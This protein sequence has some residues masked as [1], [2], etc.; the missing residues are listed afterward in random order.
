MLLKL[1]TKLHLL[2]GLIEENN[3]GAQIELPKKVT[4]AKG[5]ATSLKVLVTAVV[6]TVGKTVC[7]QLLK[8][9]EN[10]NK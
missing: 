9:G 7:L 3:G 4:F 10:K 1:L 5:N 2:W 6:E 8:K